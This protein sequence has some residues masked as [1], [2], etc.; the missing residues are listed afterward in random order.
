[1]FDAH[2][3]D[4]FSFFDGSGKA[5]ELAQLAKEKGYTALGLTNHGNTSGL[6]QHYDACKA[7][8]IKPVLGV[9]AYFLPVYKENKRGFHLCLYAKNLEGYKN[10]NAI[11]SEGEK[12][13]Y[14]N[15]IITFEILE[16]YSEG[17]I[18]S[19]ACVAGFLAQCIINNK[20]LQAKKFLK[21]M[22]KI[23]GDDLYIEIQPYKV[24]EKGLQERVNV[25]AI[26]LAEE[27]GI[28]CIF[29]SD[30][31]RGRK[32]DLESYIAM[33]MLKN[34]NPEYVNHI[35]NTYSARYMPNKD[36]M[37]KRF[38]KM[39]E[40]DL[41]IAKCKRIIAEVER[42]MDEFEEKVE[43][44]IIDQLSSVYS[45][46]KFDEEQNS[47][48][49]LKSKVKEGLKEKGIYKKNY[50][51]RALEELKV[52]KSNNFEDYFLI[53]QDYVK[54]AKNKGI[55]VGVGRG[56]GCNC[57]INYALGITEVDPIIFGLDYKR[58]IREDKKQLPDID[59]DFETDRRNE[60][61][62]YM[63]NKYKGHAVQI[64]S[65]GMYKVDNLVNDVVKLYDEMEKED[66]KNIKKLVNNHKDSEKMV[67][68]EKL[69]SN[70]LAKKY[71]AK[72]N[73]IID[74]FCFLY[75]KVKYIGTHAAG[76][77]VSKLPIYYYTAVRYDKKSNKYF[78]SYN[79]VD[80]ERIGII[81]YDM[82]GLN[83]LNSLKDYAEKS[84]VKPDILDMIKDKKILNKF[85][86]GNSDGVFQFDSHAAQS[87]L[88]QINVD[89][90]KDVVAANAMDRPGPLSLGIPEK[91][92][93][94]KETWVEKENKPVYSKYINDTY[95]CIL[96][97]EQVNSI[98][99]EY[100][101]LNWNQADKLRKMDD[102]GSFKARK[103]LEQYHDEFLNVF[104][105][106]M[107]KHGVGRS[108]ASELF[109]KFLNYTFNKGHAVGYTLISF[110]E[111]FYK[112]YY[113]TIFWQVK[114][115]YCSDENEWKFQNLAVKDGALILT[116]HVNGS[117]YYSIANVDNED[118]I[119]MGISSIKGVG[120][121]VAKSIEEER[122][123]NGNYKDIDDLCDRLPKR[124]ITSRVKEALKEN[125][126]CIFDKKRYFD[127]VMRY[128]IELASR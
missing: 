23:F 98:A 59:V 49:L 122:K 30:S 8:G 125:G 104:I 53:V 45:L 29:T 60:V 88:K 123:K 79:L 42:N 26:K 73:D 116:P 44:D 2:R 94:A 100:G 76:V 16:K 24:S 81:K 27:F 39:H 91:Y 84:G 115:K 121:K 71:N 22:L 75:N 57:L 32:E 106:G 50:I 31:H 118:C 82:L 83:T 102:P 7:V 74:N 25:E 18:C 111:M 126:A 41:G 66:I 1:M 37:Q 54:Y 12:Q 6:I 89:S 55:V 17:V 103:L 85:A 19:T 35:R 99:V 119:L 120:D 117:A 15:P 127:H 20:H 97:Q 101:G 95:G 13:K 107:K 90:F 38:L 64:A 14:Y 113:N 112:V 62:E 77:A 3:H 28:K 105:R 47:Y 114:L 9:E 10:I 51:K 48:V 40:N 69:K 65:Y 72:Y 52:I 34:K 108:E 4:E 124:I 33:H 109:G 80:L 61:I 96:Y 92:A 68:I 21:R 87:I 56:S 58:F 110:Y 128:N 5:I 86:C 63:V 46:P 78:S 36:E 93:M 11:Q 43:G 70:S 67:D